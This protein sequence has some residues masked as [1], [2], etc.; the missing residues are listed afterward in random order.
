MTETDADSMGTGH[1]FVCVNVD[2]DKDEVGVVAAFREF[3][4][5]WADP[6]ARAAPRRGVVDDEIRAGSL[7]WMGGYG[8]GGMA[9]EWGHTHVHG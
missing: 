9:G 5:I 7:G 6:L 3:D 8:R 2:L 4:K 1:L